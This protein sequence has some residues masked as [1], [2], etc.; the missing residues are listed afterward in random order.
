MTSNGDSPAL[1]DRLA[2]TATTARAKQ[3]ARM[4]RQQAAA[5]A[6]RDKTLNIDA[7]SF[8]NGLVTGLEERLSAAAE[9]GRFEYEVYRTENPSEVTRLALK[10]VVNWLEDRGFDTEL[11]DTDEDVPDYGRCRMLR[12]VAMWADK[13]GS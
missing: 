7:Q 8:R 11:T 10:M 13:S 4:K 1:A 6:A 9:Q 12:L 2:A 3:E 5:K